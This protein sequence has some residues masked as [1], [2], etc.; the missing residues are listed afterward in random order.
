MI[1][2]IE[3]LR[4]SEPNIIVLGSYPP[5]IQSILDFDFI[6]GRT[7]PSIHGVIG[8]NKKS[9][10]YFWGDK[11][12]LL[13]VYRN[14]EVTP[15]NLN[16]KIN[17]FLSVVS[18]RRVLFT[19]DITLKSLT[20]L[21]GGVIFAENTPETHS[22]KLYKEIQS[23]NRFII[24]PSSVGLLI[25][26]ILKLGAIGGVEI[27]QLFNP[28]LY[29]PG[30][31]AVLSASGGMTNELLNVVS[32][33]GKRISFCM[34]FGGDRF[35][36]TT[37]M[38]AIVSAEKDT[39][40]S[41]IIYFGELGGVDEFKIA[42]LISQNKITKPVY[43]YIAGSVSE[44]FSTPLQFGHAKAIAR[45]FNES[46]KAKMKSLKEAGAVV[47]SS[48]TELV[49]LIE[50][51]PSSSKENF[52]IDK[53]WK[54]LINRQRALFV[55][56]IS[57]ETDYG[58]RIF[59]DDLLDLAKKHSFSYIT[60][61]LLLG[62]KITSKELEE[63]VDLVMKL[64]VDNGPSVSG[65]VNTIIS[66]RAGK[67]MVSS[68]ASGLLTIGNRFGGAVNKAAENWIYGVESGINPGDFVEEHSSNA[69][70]IEGIGHK[71]YRV[72]NPDPRVKE[73][74]RWASKLKNRKFLAFAK[75]V[76]SIT[77]DKK[78]NLI[79]NVDGAMAAILLDILF[80]KEGLSIKELKRLTEV[81][82]F[83]AFFIIPRSVGFISHYL[84]QKRMDEG[85]FRLPKEE[86]AHVSR[87]Q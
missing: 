87:T 16:N 86:V 63:F 42:E 44:A 17:L 52:A 9:E 22:L 68:L 27:K 55:S 28:I 64:L 67:D 1:I 57:H 85:L 15:N 6:V 61:S 83:N 40:T 10:R 7:R 33:L 39:K 36:I 76:E 38:E 78:S 49:S 12:L 50:K 71:K 73:L 34:S 26:G 13:P 70:P 21:L 4:N 54:K 2:D 66:A 79:L 69:K 43:T 23:I 19:T 5:I 11:E 53:E 47:G 29:Q 74:R 14:L 82:F 77:T 37:P 81:E 24:G 8:L 48:F 59:D 25:P 51:I 75:K 30:N 41:H 58:V 80:E 32:S 60:A 18:A 56:T 20:N 35:P 65:A 31:I 45:N 46:A 84:D 62:K 3:K 72:E